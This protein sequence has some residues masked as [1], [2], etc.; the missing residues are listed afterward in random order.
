MSTRPN[1]T[2]KLLG[3]GISFALAV[4]GGTTFGTINPASAATHAAAVSTSSLVFNK[5]TGSYLSPSTPRTNW[6]MCYSPGNTMTLYRMNGSPLTGGYQFHDTNLPSWPLS[7]LPYPSYISCVVVHQAYGTTAGQDVKYSILI[8]NISNQTIS[9][10]SAYQAGDDN[11]F[12]VSVQ[13]TKKITLKPG[14]SQLFTGATILRSAPCDTGGYINSNVYP[15]AYGATPCITLNGAEIGLNVTPTVMPATPGLGIGHAISYQEY[16]ATQSVA[17]QGAWPAPRGACSS[18]AIPGSIAG[19]A[20]TP[21]GKGYWLATTDGRVINCGDAPSLGNVPV[22]Q[23]PIVAIVAAPKGVGYWLV[24]ETGM[25][26]AFGTAVWHG[27]I[28]HTY[29]PE[30][31]QITGSTP[32]IV[33]MAADPVTGGYWLLN[34]VGNVY[35]YDAPKYNGAPG[36][37]TVGIAALPKGTGYWILSNTGQVT[38]CGSAKNLGSAGGPSSGIVA[39][40]ATGG[41]WLV[42][43]SGDVLGFSAPG[44]AAHAA[45]SHPAGLAVLPTGTGYFLANS[46]GAVTTYGAA[47]G[48]GSA[49]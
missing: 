23:Y 43:T 26:W 7:T 34:S 12:W 33:A 9:V 4:S 30:S 2:V 15:P 27:Q 21:D 17:L 37:F 44:W 1:R 46:A 10:I 48:E 13:P 49:N 16:I 38:A 24:D 28:P 11:G 18:G 35:N 14:A 6:D 5:H 40:P 47:I 22:P 39:D 42:T 36:Q 41:Y 45:V 3:L 25:V 31:N 19:I 20:S 29:D 8:T 32:H